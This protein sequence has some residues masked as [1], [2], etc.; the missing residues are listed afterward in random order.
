MRG[1]DYRVHLRY[2]VKTIIDGLPHSHAKKLTDKFRQL[3]RFI[4]GAE[5][6]DYHR[7]ATWMEVA[8]SAHDIQQMLD[9]SKHVIWSICCAVSTRRT[10]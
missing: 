5:R 1:K 9:K 3:Q 2:S 6:D 4:H 8:A 7:H 10:A